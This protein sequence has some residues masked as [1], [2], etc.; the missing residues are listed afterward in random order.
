MAAVALLTFTGELVCRVSFSTRQ[1]STPRSRGSTSS[2]DRAAMENAACQMGDRS[3]KHFA[4]GEWAAM[5]EILA[6]NIPPKIADG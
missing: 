2:A 5:E 1:T 4:A 6:D 3:W